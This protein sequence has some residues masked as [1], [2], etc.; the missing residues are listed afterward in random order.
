MNKGTRSVLI[1]A[2]RGLLRRRLQTSLLIVALTAA[3]AGTMTIMAIL[4]GIKEQMARDLQR[5]G[6]NVVNVQVQPSLGNLLNAPI[7][8]KDTDWMREISSG[9]VAPLR[10]QMALSSSKDPAGM[11][12]TLLLSTTSRWS[13]IIPLEM[14]EGRFFKNSETGVCVLD[15]WVAR[16]LFSPGE[17]VGNDLVLHAQGTPNRLRIVGVMKDP[18][19]IRKR[20][21]HYD[22]AGS[23]RSTA[24]RIMEFKSVYAPGDFADP[25][26]SIHGA[27][28]KA[29]PG[30][31]AVRL[32]QA[33]Q[34]EADSRE[35]P[36]FIWARRAW[37][38]RVVEGADLMTRIASMFW[39]IVLLVTGMMILTISLVA[40]RERYRELAIRRTEGARRMHV[41]GQLLVENLLL[42]LTSGLLAIGLA[43]LAGR[44]LDER[45]LSWTPAFLVHEM[46]LAI[47]LGVVIGAAAT[48][49]PAYRAAS[50]DPVRV[51]R[52]A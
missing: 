13:E 29:P 39:V 12:E 20:M 49:A 16:R 31:D 9:V 24:N 30:T 32:A 46:A 14:T 22:F 8:V 43:R 26:Q 47:G 25:E 40:I 21:D 52:N 28:I 15:E 23:A 7:K 51:L 50:L 5:I 18:L 42:S 19:E 48:L 17:A 36:I 33:L 38:N 2:A 11:T 41:V 45:Y 3:I 4:S 44:V 37:V 27:V 35:L 34:A 1:F 10:V 6:L